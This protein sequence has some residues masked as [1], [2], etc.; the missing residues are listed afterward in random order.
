MRIRRKKHLEDRLAAVSDFLYISDL[1]DRNFQT[2]VL[3]PDYLDL[4]NWF[5]RQAPLYL[6]IGCGK[7]GFA[8]EFAKQNPQVNV[9]GIEKSA[10]VIVQACERAQREQISNLRFFKGGAEYLTKYLLPCSVERIFLNF[11]CP[12]PKARYASHRL[13]H[14]KFL[15]LY[16][17]VMTES[18]Q[19]HQKTDNR[20]LFEFSI[21]ALSGAGFT[22]KNISLDLHH[23]DFEG[24][25]ETEYEK[26]FVALGLP[27]YRLEACRKNGEDHD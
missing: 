8:A 1:D 23:S 20:Q 7:G 24:N 16:S 19:I 2:A 5:G 27:I 21:E 4:E 12:F 10:N 22:L 17:Q 14:P 3:E 18:A 11:S 9:L 26:K 6:E 15:R 25:I 13:T